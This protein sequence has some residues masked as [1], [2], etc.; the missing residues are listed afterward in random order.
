MIEEKG[1]TLIGSYWD[2][3]GETEIDL[4]SV[5]ELDKTAA[6]I[7]VKRNPAN[8]DMDK[9]RQKSYNFLRSTGQLKDYQ[10][11]Y[12]GISLNDIYSLST[13]CFIFQYVKRIVPKKKVI[14]SKREVIIFSY[15]IERLYHSMKLPHQYI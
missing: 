14:V 12:R 4:I 11:I 6:F 15:R 10:I 1:I 8:I 7:E 5:N 2:R 13:I 9:L 3:K